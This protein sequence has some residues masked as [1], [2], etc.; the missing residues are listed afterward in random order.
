MGFIILRYWD[1]CCKS[2]GFRKKSE[3]DLTKQFLG[4]LEKS[5]VE[6][7]LEKFR[8]HTRQLTVTNPFFYSDIR[9]KEQRTANISYPASAAA[10]VFGVYLSAQSR[11]TG[12][13]RKT[14]VIRPCV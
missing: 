8:H 11:L 1:W 14:H 6:P 3:Y 9:N 10:V 7:S 12:I 4:R 2:K 5:L 13:D